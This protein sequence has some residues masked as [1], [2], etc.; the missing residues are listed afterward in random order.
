MILLLGLSFSVRK[1]HTLCLSTRPHL[2]S[3]FVCLKECQP[4]PVHSGQVVWQGPAAAFHNMFSE[5]LPQLG[6]SREVMEGTGPACS[7]VPTV[8]KT[9]FPGHP[10]FL[11]SLAT[12]P[13]QR[14]HWDCGGTGLSRHCEARGMKG[15]SSREVRKGAMS[16]GGA[17]IHVLH[18]EAAVQHTRGFLEREAKPWLAASHPDSSGDEWDVIRAANVL[19]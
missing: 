16:Q 18:D 9:S 7:M 19:P 8:L 17:L 1:A 13:Q 10:S 12:L 15:S 6:G 4:Q 14:L 5:Q 11:P 3:T 2:Y